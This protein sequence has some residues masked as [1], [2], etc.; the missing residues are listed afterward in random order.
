MNMVGSEE[1]I[2]KCLDGQ[3]HKYLQNYV[4]GVNLTISL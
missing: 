4:E 3:V 2:D 1:E